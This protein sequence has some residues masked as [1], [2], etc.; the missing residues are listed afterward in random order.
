L[1]LKRKR[2]ACPRL[3]RLASGL[4]MSTSMLSLCLLK[5]RLAGIIKLP[6][7]YAK[8]T[9][10]LMLR[11]FSPAAGLARVSQRRRQPN[12][13]LLLTTVAYWRRELFLVF[14]PMRNAASTRKPSC[15]ACCAQVQ[16][17]QA[18]LAFPQQVLPS[19]NSVC[20]RGRCPSVPFP[21]G[22]I[23]YRPRGSSLR[24]ESSYLQPA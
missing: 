14:Q 7:H 24:S 22:T 16:E 2:A 6:A 23:R 9:P 11:L 15:P 20:P 8:G 12:R 5:Y 19:P 3:A 10:L 4:M 1:R 17:R 18:T 21:H 13:I